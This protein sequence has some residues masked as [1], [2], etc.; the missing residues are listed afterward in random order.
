MLVLT[1]FV[2]WKVGE[3]EVY[4]SASLLWHFIIA[5]LFKQ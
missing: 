4:K 5:G 1:L 2:I 3:L